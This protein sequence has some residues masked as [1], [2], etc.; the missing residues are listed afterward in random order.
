MC[1]QLS[2]AEE[3]VELSMGMSGDFEQAVRLPGWTCTRTFRAAMG[4]HY[5]VQTHQMAD[6]PE[7]YFLLISCSQSLPAAYIC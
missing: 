4:I 3:A 1:Q 7:F 2:L 5:G 6:P